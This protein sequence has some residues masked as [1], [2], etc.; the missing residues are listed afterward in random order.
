MTAALIVVDFYD[1]QSA[2]RH[3][4][5]LAVSAG[6]VV[7]S[8]EG[9]PAITCPRSEVKVLSRLR[10]APRRIEFPGGAVAVTQDDAWVDDAFQVS[11]EA[12]LAHR[13]ESHTGFILA[14]MLGI[15][16][17]MVLGYFY[18]IPLAAREIAGRMPDGIEKNIAEQG[19]KSLDQLVF[20]PT[21]LSLEKREEITNL[22]STLRMEAGLPNEIR[23]EFRE[24]DWI[25]ANAL[26]L[27]GGVVVITDELVAAMPGMDE[28]AA[29]LAHELGHVHHR[30]SLRQLLQ[31][32][33]TAMAALAIYGDVTVISGLA[34]SAPTVLAH[35][36]YSRDH[37]RESDVFAFALLKK[38]GRSPRAFASAM[39]A[40]EQAHRLSSKSARYP[41]ERSK[42]K[43][44]PEQSGDSAEPEKR[45]DGPTPRAGSARATIP[46]YLATHPATAERI[47][48]ALDAAEK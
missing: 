40:L 32:S 44:V 18:G 29:V 35:T 33:L 9:M 46:D 27:P 1:G 6:I 36:G 34:A 42:S 7:L 2:T 22:F 10:G 15:A 31:S 26:A 16:V 28:I 38:I 12:T 43:K 39:K 17:T 13:L 21:K 47:Q 19:L 48:A 45:N 11:A 8:V 4:A 3:A 25:E 41:W 20:E 5:T 30:H 37:E 14:A 24:G 23:L